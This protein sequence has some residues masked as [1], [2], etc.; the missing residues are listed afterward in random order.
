MANSVQFSD[1]QLLNLNFLLTIQASIRKDPVAACYKFKLTAEQAPK[2]ADLSLEQL[3]TF[4]ANLGHECLFTLR[5]DFLQMLDSPPGLLRALST[6]RASQQ[7]HS[8]PRP[9]ADAAG[10]AS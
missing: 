10:G 4:V 1:V 2:I 7:L 3:Q 5:E 8:L 6:V 9:V